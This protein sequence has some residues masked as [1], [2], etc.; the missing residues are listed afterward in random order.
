LKKVLLEAGAHAN[1]ALDGWTPLMIAS[2]RGCEAVVAALLEATIEVN[3][4]GAEGRTAL[5]LA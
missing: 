4:T 1:K 3:R 5:L 2:W